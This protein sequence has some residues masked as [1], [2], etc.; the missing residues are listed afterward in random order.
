VARQLATDR[1]R[2]AAQ[3]GRDRADLLTPG[4]YQR[5]LFALGERQT[6]TLQIAAATRTHATRLT[7]PRQAAMAV[8]TGDR[9]RVGEELTG[10]QRGPERLNRL[11]TS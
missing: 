5:D 1:R 9:G 11:S 8:R 10:L 4:T 6:A 2:A 3:P 7:Q